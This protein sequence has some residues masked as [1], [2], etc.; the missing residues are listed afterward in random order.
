LLSVPGL[1]VEPGFM[2]SAGWRLCMPLVSLAGGM[3]SVTPLPIALEVSAPGRGVNVE[4][5]PAPPTA[6]SVAPTLPGR[7]LVSTPPAPVVYP[8]V[9]ERVG[10]VEDVSWAIRR[11]ANAP[12]A[13]AAARAVK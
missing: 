2:L 13:S 4:L 8:E 3:L 10:V 6:V 9:S 1:V 12:R 11:G 5:S 7:A